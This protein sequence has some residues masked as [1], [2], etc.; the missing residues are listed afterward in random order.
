M[1]RQRPDLFFL[2]RMEFAIVCFQTFP[3]ANI[4]DVLKALGV[5][6]CHL[7]HRKHVGKIGRA[8]KILPFILQ[9]G[10]ADLFEQAGVKLFKWAPENGWERTG[11]LG[12]KGFAF[13]SR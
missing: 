8:L 2:K 4:E 9:I 7:Q 13:P 5:P 3:I 12:S 6:L 10:L 1:R 11:F